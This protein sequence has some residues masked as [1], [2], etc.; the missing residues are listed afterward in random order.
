MRTEVALFPLHLVLFPG[1]TLP[2]HVFEDRYRDMVRGLVDAPQ[3]SPRHFGVVAIRA[4]TDTGGHPDVHDV[5]CL[6]VLREVSELPDGRYDV[7][8]VGG[9]RFRV[10]ELDR[11]AALLRAQVELLDERTGDAALGAAVVRRRFAAYLQALGEARGTG[12]G[13]PD[14]PV[15]PTVLSYV[16]AATT[17]LEQGERQELL[18]RPD[19]ASRLALAAELLRRETMLV[20]ATS[21][22]PATDFTRAAPPPF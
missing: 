21:T 18:G 11:S 15:D 4:G 20:R 2:L 12:L 1:A 16:V 10:L 7:V 9:A 17:V 3:G 13:V 14:L 22:V 6:A 8:T 5:G 19:S